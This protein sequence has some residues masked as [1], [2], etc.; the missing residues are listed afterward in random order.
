M[1]IQAY[2]HK[3]AQMAAKH[4][5][6]N[7]SVPV[8][9]DITGVNTR[10]VVPV[11]PKPVAP[12]S[13]L[14]QVG[15]MMFN[16]ATTDAARLLRDA[17]A[18]NTKE[19]RSTFN[20]VETD[21]TFSMAAALYQS[22]AQTPPWR[23]KNNS[24]SLTALLQTREADGTLETAPKPQFA[25]VKHEVGRACSNFRCEFPDRGILLSDNSLFSKLNRD[26]EALRKADV[27][28][29]KMSGI[30]TLDNM[31]GAVDNLRAF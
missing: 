19:T 24:I 16:Q 22:F 15:A 6:G 31:K 12:Q 9:D 1:D 29:H 30:G 5:P 17:K 8:N 3:C 7:I 10:P 21:S 23:L 28:E 25:V 18:N 26:I 2:I 4:S 13:A 14:A 27:A 20:W 11:S